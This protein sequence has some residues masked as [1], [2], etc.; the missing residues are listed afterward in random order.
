[1]RRDK[2]KCVLR[3]RDVWGYLG[4]SWAEKGIREVQ[5]TTCRSNLEEGG[6][7]WEGGG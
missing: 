7:L 6:L 3:Y 4:A 1:M 5:K 2:L